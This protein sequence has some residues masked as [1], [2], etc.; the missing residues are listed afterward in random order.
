[1]SDHLFDESILE[2]LKKTELKDG[3]CILCT[4]SILNGKYLNIPDSTKAWVED[5]FIKK[6]GKDI[7]SYNVIDTGIFMCSPSI[8]D[9]LEESIS[10]GK[11][12]LSAGNQ[13]LSDMGKLKNLDI[14]GNYWIDVDDDESLKNAKNILIKNL[15]KPNDG[16]VSKYLNRPISTKISSKLTNYNISPN[17]ITIFSF[18]IALL[19]A[20]F[21]Y[22]GNS[23]IYALIGGILA[24]FSS[25]VDGCDG[26]IARLKFKSSKFGTWLDRILDRYADGLIIVGITNYCFK[27]YSY[28]LVFLIGFFALIGTF[29][30]SYSAIPYDE[31]L[32]NGSVIRK[33][34]F[35]F[36]RD[37][38]LFIVF[39]GAV[40]NQLFLTLIF[41][42]VIT[43]LENIR[44]LFVIKHRYQ[45]NEKIERKVDE[46]I[47]TSEVPEEYPY[48][49]M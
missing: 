30:N 22:F 37:V 19:S 44:R 9:A 18:A 8:F 28:E 10:R 3:N 14:T 21:F 12:S 42:A 43:N 23:Y 20:L 36:G 25:I 46:I 17:N 2:K 38:R 34:S 40:F 48:K 15:T 6:I 39:I 7:E 41:I 11:Y 27:T 47:K 45:P 1:M 33:N 13:V 4:D 16:P 31:V 35:R 32:K 26:E 29:I 49:K 24:Q 5:S